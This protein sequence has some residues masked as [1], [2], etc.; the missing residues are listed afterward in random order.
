MNFHRSP[1]QL[2][3]G[4]PLFGWSVSPV[5]DRAYV[6]TAP[7]SLTLLAQGVQARAVF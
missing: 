6:F 4:R 3:F 1:S 5:D 7:S 2:Y